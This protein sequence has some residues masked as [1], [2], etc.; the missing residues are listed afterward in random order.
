[1]TTLKARLYD[2]ETAASRTV[3]VKLTVPG[4]LIIQELS[5]LSRYRLEDVRIAEQLGSQPARVTLPDGTLLEVADSQTFFSELQNAGGTRQWLHRLESNW[6]WA[7][8]AV[9]VTVAFGWITYSWGIPAASKRVAYAMPLE[10]DRSIGEQGLELLDKKF[11]AP[12]ELSG[13][14]QAE[15]QDAFARVVES[16]GRDDDYGYRLEFRGGGQLGANAIALPAGI[17]VMTDEL[18]ALS[19]HDAE[20]AAIMAHEVGHIRNR[21]SLRMLLQNSAVAVLVITLTGDISSATSLAASVPTVLA[22]AGYSRQ[23]EYEADAVAKEYLLAA[24]IP[25]HHFA[26][27]LLRMSADDDASDG[28]L[29]LLDTHP[30]S[31]DRA[32]EFR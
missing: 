32:G 5:A 4:Y 29:S 16:V 14:R 25:L 7:L 13:S 24:G 30:A 9:I 1:M 20:L 17:V 10:V 18:V 12:S 19:E 31:R 15:L 26:D 3:Q 2:G 27:I 23:F 11:F 22:Q 8:V 6:G 21:H 28:V